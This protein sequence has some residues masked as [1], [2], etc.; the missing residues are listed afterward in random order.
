MPPL[1]VIHQNARLRIHNRRLTVELDGKILTSLPINQVNQVVLFGNVGLTT[2][3]IKAL[4][5]SN[6]DVV[7]L[8][9]RGDF[10]GRLVGEISPHV[11]LRRK[12][13][14]Q[15]GDSEFSL[16]MA[17]GFVTAKIQHQIA[18]LKRSQ[19]KNPYAEIN[20]SIERIQNTLQQIEN[21]TTIKSLRGLEGSSTA[22]YFR[23]LK[24]LFDPRWKF[25]NRNRRPPKDPV[26]VLLS[27]G[28]TLITNLSTSMIEITG[29]DPYAGFL[30]E[31]VYNR[32]SLALDLVE[33][34]RPV[35][36]GLALWCCN[37]GI[38]STSNFSPGTN[39][40]PVVLDEE[41]KAHFLR[42]Y[43][44]RISRKS[45]NP[46]NG[47]MLTLRR[48]ILEQARQIVNRIKEN[49]PGYTGMGFR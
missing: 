26:N 29:L 14:Q 7:F 22:A 47:E 36:D 39:E 41:G 38:L 31:L 3:A 21:K 49:Q 40:R 20:N 10:R 4:L 8:T 25:K 24:L 37:S 19:R 45:A 33:E 18:L 15:L 1:Y 5:R 44:E 12:Q 35:I 6:C 2:P 32:P 11:P 13:Y 17:K 43:E 48:N 42:A 23:G 46:I 9:K 28:Y 16:R 30:H 34:F 27:F